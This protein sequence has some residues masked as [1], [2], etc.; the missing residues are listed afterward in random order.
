VLLQG[1]SYRREGKKWNSDLH[2]FVTNIHKGT[3]FI[4]SRF[5]SK[6]L[7]SPTYGLISRNVF[8][9]RLI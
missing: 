8:F 4:S 7:K 1:R 9:F 2:G 3:H 6:T 5:L